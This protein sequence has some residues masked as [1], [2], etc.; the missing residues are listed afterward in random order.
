VFFLFYLAL[1]LGLI[2]CYCFSKSGTQ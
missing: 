2:W 1:L